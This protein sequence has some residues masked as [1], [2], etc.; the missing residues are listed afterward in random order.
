MKIRLPSLR[1]I[2][3]A[4][5]DVLVLAAVTLWGFATHD[6]LES[7]GIRLLTTF[8]PLVVAWFLVAPHL[9][10]FDDS[11]TTRWRELWRPFWAM[12]LGGP[13][14]V[15]LRGAV[16]NQPII[17]LFVVILGGISALAILAWRIV[18]LLIKKRSA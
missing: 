1:L 11:R 18:Y 9:K 5:G 7:A 2:V 3:L 15:F 12:V 14:A 4:L 13:I 16:L 6:A 8:I 17:P 10:A